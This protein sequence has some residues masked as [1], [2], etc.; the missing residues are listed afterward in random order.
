[1]SRSKYI[2]V[3]ICAAAV[4][5][6][7]YRLVEWMLTGRLLVSPKYSAAHYVSWSADHLELI[8]GAVL[9]AVLIL[10]ALALMADTVGKE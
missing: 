6:F 3:A 8:I 1:M 7:G 10:A 4:V 2:T 9:T 5:L